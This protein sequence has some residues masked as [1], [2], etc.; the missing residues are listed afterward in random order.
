ML[1][2]RLSCCMSGIVLLRNCCNLRFLHN[3]CSTKTSACCIA[4]DVKHTFRCTS[5]MIIYHDHRNHVPPSCISPSK[6]T[7]YCSVVSS[8]YSSRAISLVL[9]LIEVHL[10]VVCSGFLAVIFFLWT[11]VLHF[12]FVVRF[13]FMA[14]EGDESNGKAKAKAKGSSHDGTG[15]MGEAD[16]ERGLSGAIKGLFAGRLMNYIEV[17]HVSYSSID[18][19]QWCFSWNRR[20]ST[21]HPS[22]RVRVY[23][24]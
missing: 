23:L 9:V 16:K 21:T 12:F 7:K 18:R 11:Y 6:S 4:L 19:W 1:W 24:Y 22:I 14:L 5:Y 3:N 17:T 2:P 20:L 13:L 10:G 8:C 15:G